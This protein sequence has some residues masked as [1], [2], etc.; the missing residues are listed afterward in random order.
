[1]NYLAASC[2]VSKVC[3]ASNPDSVTP[4]CFRSSS[5]PHALGGNPGESGTGRPI[6]TQS[7]AGNEP[8]AIQQREV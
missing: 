4:E 8:L 7:A 1:M 2:G 6:K 3:H 5:F